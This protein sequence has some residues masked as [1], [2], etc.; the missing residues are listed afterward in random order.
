M[1]KLNWRVLCHTLDNNHVINPKNNPK[2]SGK[3]LCTCI[4][5]YNNIDLRYLRIKEF[6]VENQHWH[7]EDHK[8]AISDVI[9][10]WSDVDMYMGND[11]IVNH[12]VVFDKDIKY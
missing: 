1:Q 9:L 3:Y 11:F 5:K 10:A 2:K 8:F 6:D 12:G 7:D 4:V